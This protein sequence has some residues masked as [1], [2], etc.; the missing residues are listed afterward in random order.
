MAVLL[1]FSLIK[2]G[3]SAKIISMHPLVH[4]WSREQMIKSKQQKIWQMGG[5]ILSCAIPH[6]F[7]SEDYALCHLIFPHI[8]AHQ[9]HGSEIWLTEPYYYDK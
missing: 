4:A 7:T 5:I 3:Q 2:K 1:A 8:R 9:A 6:R